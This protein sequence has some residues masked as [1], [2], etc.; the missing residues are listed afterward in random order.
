VIGM[1]VFL[2]VASAGS[3]L[4]AMALRAAVEEATR[5]GESVRRIGDLQPALVAIRRDSLR[6]ADAVREMRSR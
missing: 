6:A 3:A 4:I 1:V 5:L 2:V